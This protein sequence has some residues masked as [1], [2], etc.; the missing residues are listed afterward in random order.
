MI[1]LGLA[2]GWKYEKLG[3]YL[4]II[5]MIVGFIV[6]IATQADFP[7]TFL[8]ALIPGILYLIV[9]YKK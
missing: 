8:I 2:L 1:L 5:P 4:I 7:S 6:G 3:G 9:G